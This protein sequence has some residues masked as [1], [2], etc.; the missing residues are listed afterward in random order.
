MIARA[1]S[2]KAAGRLLV[3]VGLTS[4][5]MLV[6]LT[7]LVENLFS[8]VAGAGFFVPRES[9]VLT[10]RVLVD[11]PGSGEWWLRGEDRRNFYALD[12]EEP[13][14]LVFPKRALGE[15]PGFS[16][17]DLAS[18]CPEVTTRSAVRD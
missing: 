3:T 10:F 8:L 15:C 4:V 16:P 18:W 2:A 1:G 6:L 11:N 12:T 13:V 7:P 17:M 14:Y 5:T 9:S